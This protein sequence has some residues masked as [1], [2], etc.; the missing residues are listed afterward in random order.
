MHRT[1]VKE[2]RQAPA[3]RTPGAH[4]A[5]GNEPNL[6]LHV[7]PHL[8]DESQGSAWGAHARRRVPGGP[9]HQRAA[10]CC[11][12]R[13]R[14]AA[15]LLPL[16]QTRA[17]PQAKRATG[18]GGW[19]ATLELAAGRRAVS[20]LWPAQLG[21]NGL[22]ASDERDAQRAGHH[23]PARLDL[24][25]A[26]TAQASKQAALASSTTPA[27]AEQQ[28]LGEAPQRAKARASS[29]R[30]AR[31]P[32]PW[33]RPRAHF[34]VAAL[35]HVVDVHRD[36]GVGAD[37]VLLHETDELGLSQLVGRRRLALRARV[38]TACASTPRGSCARCFVGVGVVDAAP[39]VFG[40]RRRRW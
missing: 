36:G 32:Q 6:R 27:A 2:R 21:V 16:R 37:A 40:G 8:R 13:A 38:R 29:P 15:A 25:G 1:Q 14:S 20:H 10:P 3:Q 12:C 11:A 39:Q 31:P 5:G 18:C 30:C 4:L 23:P 33:R 17:A 9:R 26:S 28:C 34:D 7:R 24:R 35:A 22:V 19:R